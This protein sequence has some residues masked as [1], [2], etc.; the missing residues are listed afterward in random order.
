MSWLR[1]LNLKSLRQARVALAFVVIAASLMTLWV[2]HA[3]HK[4]ALEI[5]VG[6]M[7]AE[8]SIK[9]TQLARLPQIPTAA[10]VPEFDPRI[11]L[12]D[13]ENR[14]RDEFKIESVSPG[15]EERVEFWLKI[16]SLYDSNKKVIHD[17]DFPWVV[18]KVVDVEPIVNAS[19]PKRRW[20][21]N[22]VADRVVSGEAKLVREALKLIALRGESA[23]SDDP[24]LQR[25]L[26]QVIES[27]KALPG[28]LRRQAQRAAREVR[29]QTGQRDFFAEGLAR[30]P[31]YW[32]TMEEIF[33]KHRLPLELTR[34]PLVESSFNKE[35]HS[36]VGAVGVWQFM[37]NT[38]RKFLTVNS[39][40]DERKSVFK[41]TEAAARLMKENY[42][43]LGRS[44][45]FAL[46][47]WN[48]GPG[49]VRKASQAARSKDFATVIERYQSRRFD[50][51]STNFFPCFLAALYAERYSDRLFPDVIRME[52]ALVKPVKI[53]RPTLVTEII[54]VAGLSMEEFI[55]IN[56][57]FEKIAL[58]KGKLPRG[59]FIHVPSDA[60][61]A[62]EAYMYDQG[63]ERLTAAND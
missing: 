6:V 12:E 39:V 32:P 60:R 58:R 8:P 18:Y 25:E 57:E 26:P 61:S 20:Q 49:G 62:V 42:M 10:F 7:D 48:H 40:V 28:D 59:Y 37:E 5:A 41:S 13:R 55:S 56:P 38:G 15:L 52:Q 17:A 44:W 36:K 51:A 4:S 33:A 54:K 29:V 43:I 9:T 21:R 34:L 53:P 46:T 2:R 63:S 35:A 11:V 14:I 16:Y 22:Q 45:P 47:A 31:R 19:H 24:D 1:H 23:K 3:E 27:L 30:G 50:F